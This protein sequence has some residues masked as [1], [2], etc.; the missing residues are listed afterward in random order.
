MLLLLFCLYGEKFCM[1]MGQFSRKAGRKQ[2]F[3]TGSLG[4][5]HTDQRTDYRSG[6][7]TGK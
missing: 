4:Y 2:K 3:F 6:T 7:Q 1:T 5:E